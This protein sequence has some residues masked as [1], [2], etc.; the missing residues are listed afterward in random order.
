MAHPEHTAR[1]VFS[2]LPNAE[3]FDHKKHYTEE[4]IVRAK[5]SPS[6]NFALYAPF[7]EDFLSRVEAGTFVAD[8]K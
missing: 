2:L 6:S 7:F 4:E 1:H 5:E 8:K 3:F